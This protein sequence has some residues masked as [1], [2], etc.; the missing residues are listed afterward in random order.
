[1]TTDKDHWSTSGLY[2]CYD[3]ELVRVL[4]CEKGS[5]LNGG[6]VFSTLFLE[7]RL[8]SKQG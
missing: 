3:Y 7:H 6:I 4:G 2:L 8:F 1:M 5:M